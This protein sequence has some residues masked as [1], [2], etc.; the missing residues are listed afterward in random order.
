METLE[1]IGHKG[2]VGNATFQWLNNMT[3]HKVVGRDLN[4]PIPDY[5]SHNHNKIV[6]FICVP[7]DKVKEVAYTA[8]EYAS[9]IVVRSTV[10]P[11][12]CKEIQEQTGVHTIHNPEFLR[13]VSA[14]PDMFNPSY[15]LIGGCCEQHAVYLSS[16]YESACAPVYITDQITS[17]IAKLAHNS[18]LACLISFWNEIENIATKLGTSGSK[19]GAILS[20]DP[21]I[22]E[23]GARFH[24]QFG[25]K[26]LPKDLAHLIQYAIDVDVEPTMLEAIREVN[27]CQRLLSPYPPLMSKT[28]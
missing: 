8:S 16:L 11:H 3:S 17:E 24:Q 28:L 4:D 23:Y 10:I 1:V 19:I 5:K 18:Y 21:R 20:T 2:V 25:G 13:E 27:K 7:D 9:L 12:T 15:I 22:S 26:C 6:S 14:L